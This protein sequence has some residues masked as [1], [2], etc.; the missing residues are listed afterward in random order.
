M[1]VCIRIK[2]CTYSVLDFPVSP[3]SLGFPFWSSYEQQ[4]SEERQEGG[5][6]QSALVLEFLLI[7]LQNYTGH[8][9]VTRT[10]K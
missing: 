8:F 10:I 6:K 5:K 9:Q 7:N 2:E 3:F 4:Q 1:F